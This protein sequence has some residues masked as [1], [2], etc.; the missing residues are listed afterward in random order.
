MA[1]RLRADRTLFIVTVLL[2]FVGL[3][4]VFSA[5]AVVAQERFGSPYAF[6]LRQLLWA[7]AGMAALVGTM[8]LDYRRL[9]HPAVVFCILAVTALLLT[10]VFFLDRSHNT[11]RWIRFGEFSFQPAELAKPA[12]IFF[13]AY[14]LRDRLKGMDD[15]RHTL[16]PA[17]IPSVLFAGMIALQPDLGTSVV[18]LA[19]TASVLFVAGMRMRY[20]GY[21]VGALL[22]PLYLLL[23]RVP[24]RYE[25]LLAFVNPYSDPQGRGFHI[26]QSLIAVG[27]G[28]FAGMG[29]M[30]G[31]QK[32]FYLPEPHTDFIF[33]VTA[34]ELGLLGS[35]VVLLL[36]G[37][38]L[39]RGIRSALRTQDM[40]G[41][42]LAVGITSMVAVQAFINIR[43]VLG[44]MPTKGIPLPFVSEGGSS[45]FVTLACVGVL[46]NITKQTD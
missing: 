44:I 22:F 1:K 39:W 40:Y 7:I 21:A 28:G 13:L 34:D 31:K 15:W 25:R 29:L 43:V 37:I 27:T 24:W 33:T 19:I 10:A 46:L 14:F 2:L 35:L 4:M 11:H 36:F 6:F 18:C 20:F 5:S 8:K 17:A 16:L 9:N 23:F 32:L 45:V 42:L 3:V 26:I 38:F 30:E 41:R 12:I